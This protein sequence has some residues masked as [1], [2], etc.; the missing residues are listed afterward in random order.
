MHAPLVVQ[1]APGSSL[2][3]EPDRT[4]DLPMH[5][6]GPPG[7][8][9][10]LAGMHI[11]L[12]TDQIV[13]IEE[14][15]GTVRAGFGGMHFTGIEDGRLT[16]LRVRDLWPEERLSPARSWN[17]TLE[18]EWVASVHEQGRQVWP[19]PAS[20]PRAGLCASCTHGKVVTSS[21]GSVF[22]LCQRSTTDTSF[23]RYPA[24][25]RLSCRGYE[26]GGIAGGTLL[27]E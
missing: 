23:P 9:V 12:P 11:S 21:R 6:N 8:F 19:A 27:A 10:R 5:R 22:L 2:R 25:P 17:M 16:F 14:R 7:T 1:F 20:H 18:P 26:A 15:D 4:S 3:Q 24:L 13:A